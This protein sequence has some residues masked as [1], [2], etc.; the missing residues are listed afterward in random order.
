[1]DLAV[2]G[3]EKDAAEMIM[4]RNVL[5]IVIDTARA[6]SF[7]SLGNRTETT[8][9][10]DA[11]GR[12][13]M[14]FTRCISPAPWTTPS[15]ASIFTGKYPS[16]H[17]TYGRNIHFTSQDCLASEFKKAGYKTFGISANRLVSSMNGFSRG[18]DDFLDPWTPFNEKPLREELDVNDSRA[19]KH[20][21]VE[22]LSI[23]FSK[24]GLNAH[25]KRKFG[26]N[27]NAKYSTN[28]AIRYVKRVFESVNE[29]KFMFV[30]I[31]Q[32]HEKY[33]PP[34]EYVKKL[35]YTYEKI[36]WPSFLGHYAGI[37]KIDEYTMSVLR[38]LYEGE[39]CYA[40]EKIA[41]LI[42]WMRKKEYLNNTTVIITSDH[43]EHI[44]EHGHIAHFF[45]LYNEL[46]HVPLIIRHPDHLGAGRKEGLV[47]THDIYR[48]LLESELG[49]TDRF[50][51]AETGYG[52]INLFSGERQKAVSQLL[53]SLWVK[54]VML[55]NPEIK[56]E[57]SEL[58]SR[59]TALFNNN[60]G[61]IEK[62]I[63][64]SRKGISV[65]DLSKDWGET[66]PLQLNS[67][68]IAEAERAVNNAMEIT[69]F[70]TGEDK[71]VDFSADI[72]NQLTDLGYM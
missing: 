33:N 44:G 57:T 4:K 66:E 9:A 16:E 12:E 17:G 71:D 49:L 21:F 70:E 62:I 31:M 8:P 39:L 10:L 20:S 40:D 67:D 41:S 24:E 14:Y 11:L 53:Y 26:V 22:N 42:E 23:L 50:S 28:R 37:E 5:L 34:P 36:P 1:M 61:K 69:N 52:Q 18:F 47:Q 2:T 64:D 32:P 25:F 55:L 30:N 27:Q 63:W 15:H 3:P 59:Q 46:L 65:F 48:T 7:S 43:G 29:P 72:K 68:G 51:G 38:T 60:D 56:E 35:G 58:A 45:S 6:K 54:G 13:G 19:S